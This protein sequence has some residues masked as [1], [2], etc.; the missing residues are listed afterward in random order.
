MVVARAWREE[1]APSN[2]YGVSVGGD[3][4]VLGDGD[5]STITCM[6]LMPLNFILK[7]G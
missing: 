5:S 6:C 4:H 7:N 1:E 3:E 2:E